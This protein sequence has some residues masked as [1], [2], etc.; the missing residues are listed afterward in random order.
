[1]ISETHKMSEPHQN[2]T[3]NDGNI[4]ESDRIEKGIAVEICKDK[5]L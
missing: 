2:S 5:Y 4:M 1:M 3:N